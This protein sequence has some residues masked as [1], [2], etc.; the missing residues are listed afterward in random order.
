MTTPQVPIGSGFGFETT[1]DEALAGIDLSGKTIVVTGGYSGIGIENV[2]TF[3]S[4]GATVVVPARRPDQARDV[5]AGIERVEIDELDLADLDSVRLF[6]ERFLASRRPI[7]ILLN[8]AG[9]M[10]NPETRVSQA[11]SRSSRRTTSVTLP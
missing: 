7:E 4:A 5:L 8:N 10:A 3:S 1:V 11:G 9:V 2:R 6:A